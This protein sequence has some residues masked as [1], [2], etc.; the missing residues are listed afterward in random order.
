MLHQL[1]HSLDDLLF[2][3]QKCLLKRSTGRDGMERAGEP[4]HLAYRARSIFHE[5]R[6]RFCPKGR[7][8]VPLFHHQ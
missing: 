7:K 6:H 1:H 2:A 3:G 5:L 4:A 8:A